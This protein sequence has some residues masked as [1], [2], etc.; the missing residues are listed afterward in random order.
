MAAIS[1]AL[2]ALLKAGDHIV[3][4]IESYKPTRLFFKKILSKFGITATFVSMTDLVAIR[5]AII[6][7]KTK[8]IAFESP[9]NPVVRVAD[10]AG[11]CE[12]AEKSGVIS[13]MDNTFSGFHNHG[14]FKVDLFLHSLTKFANG[15]GDSMGGAIIGSKSLIET[16]R[17]YAVDIGPCMDANSAFLTL[18]GMKTYSL[19]YEKAA[20]N[21]LKIAES[22]ANHKKISQL[23]YPG[24]DS[25]PDHKLARKQ[26]HDF[27]T[28][29]ALYLKSDSSGIVRLMN[30]LKVFAISASL[31]AVESLVAPV[32]IFYGTDLSTEE[33]KTALISPNAVRLSIGIEDA[34]DLLKDL[35]QA[36]E[37]V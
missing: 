25:H 23:L 3:L 22:L 6:P 18:R 4:C 30:A 24:L 28:V 27:G 8:L 1:T 33:K 19:R 32:E 13:I 2:L 15:H 21:A 36:L 14:Q 35:M 12:I 10:I 31:G 7:G 37:F 29:M 26:M 9:T 11:I 20:K 34:D 16:I 5:H 17:G